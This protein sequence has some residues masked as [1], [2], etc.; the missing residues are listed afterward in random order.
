M[1]K[2]ELSIRHHHTLWIGVLCGITIIVIL[3][4]VSNLH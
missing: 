2:V 1:D 4:V 3:A